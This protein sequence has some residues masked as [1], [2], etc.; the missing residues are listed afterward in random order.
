MKDA[1]RQYINTRRDTHDAY[2]DAINRAAANQKA[3]DRDADLLIAPVLK[4]IIAGGS[5][6]VTSRGFERIEDITVDISGSNVVP[7]GSY[8]FEER[9]RFNE[10][11]DP[12]HA[13]AIIDATVI[14]C[15]G[16]KQPDRVFFV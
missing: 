16:K 14:C 9:I 15:G 4:D 2:T 5:F 3:D 12:E 11:G 1:L 8:S 7:D 13:M 10:D 6:V